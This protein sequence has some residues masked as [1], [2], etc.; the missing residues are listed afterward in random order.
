MG[1]RISID[2]AEKPEK[3][4]EHFLV[5]LSIECAFSSWTA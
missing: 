1:M 3:G 4:S 5:E 2:I